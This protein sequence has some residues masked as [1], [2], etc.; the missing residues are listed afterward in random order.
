[1]TPDEDMIRLDAE[2]QVTEEQGTMMLTIVSV[3]GSCA[4]K[5][6]L[7]T[8]IEQAT[9][10]VQTMRA[11]LRRWLQQRFGELSAEV[12]TRIDQA[13]LPALEAAVDRVHSLASLADLQL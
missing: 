1:M 12:L 4:V 7:A 5:V 3:D 2:V 10:A 13:D 9:G 8:L 6:P 11:L